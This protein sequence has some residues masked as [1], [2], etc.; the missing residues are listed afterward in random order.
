M[1]A[2]LVLLLCSVLSAIPSLSRCA[3]LAPEVTLATSAGPV[4]LK[5]LRGKVV[6]VDFWASWCPPCRASFPWLTDLQNRYSAKGF[7]VLAI[8]LDR[9]RKAADQ[10]LE[11]RSV[12]FTVAYDPSAAS[13]E[14]FKV[15][16]M[17]SSYLIGPGGEILLFHAGFDPKET[18]PLEARIRQE[19]AK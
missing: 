9:D 4:S 1:R 11:G 10:F 19:C 7:R 16:A 8:N 5:S 15:K 12:P 17:P 2:V 6:L 13:A 3:D 14:A 18:G